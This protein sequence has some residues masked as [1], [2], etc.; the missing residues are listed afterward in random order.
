[1]LE[2]RARTQHDDLLARSQK[3]FGD[4]RQQRG[5]RRLDDEVGIRLERVDGVDRSVDTERAK[6]GLDL[7]AVACAD[8]RE[9]DTLDPAREPAHE[10][11]PYRSVACDGDA[12]HCVGAGSTVSKWSAI[13]RG[14]VSQTPRRPARCAT[15]SRSLRS[16][17][18]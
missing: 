18:G 10:L 1:M 16:R 14:V 4:R 13:A 8:R 9:V 17:N 7:G 12:R 6:L 11:A 2:Q 15:A 5:G 3:R